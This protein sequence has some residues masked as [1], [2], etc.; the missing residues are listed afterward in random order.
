MLRT[1]DFLTLTVVQTNATFG[2]KMSALYVCT[3][4]CLFLYVRT[5]I[6]MCVC[7]C[8]CV[9]V[10]VHCMCILSTYII[11]VTCMDLLYACG[12]ILTYILILR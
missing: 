7:A 11:Y 3:R 6:C 9:C 5:Y 2:Q 4:V 12:K 8:M 1:D 10:C